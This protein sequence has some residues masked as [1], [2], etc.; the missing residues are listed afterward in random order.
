MTCPACGN[1]VPDEPVLDTLTIC[2]TCLASL[3]REGY[4]YRRAVAEDTLYLTDPELAALRKARK[5][6]RE[7]QP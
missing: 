2:P 1:A 7:A 3:V 6:A 4:H 5:Q